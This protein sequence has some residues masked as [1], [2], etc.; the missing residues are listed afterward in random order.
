MIKTFA[1]WSF[2]ASKGKVKPIQTK[3]ELQSAVQV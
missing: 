1:A 3:L 2:L